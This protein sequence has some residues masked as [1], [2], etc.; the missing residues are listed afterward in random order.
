MITYV[1]ISHV[2]AISFCFIYFEVSQLGADTFRMA[3]SS[4]SFHIVKYP[5]LLLGNIT[6]LEFYLSDINI[7][8]SAH[9]EF[10]FA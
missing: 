3:M 4:D 7:A 10:L 1:S 9:L 5:P 2:S 8:T 6:L